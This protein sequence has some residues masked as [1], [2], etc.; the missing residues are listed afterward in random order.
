MKTSVA[1][2]AVCL[3][4]C[5]MALVTTANANPTGVGENRPLE[6]AEVAQK[7]RFLKAG[8]KKGGKKGGYGGKKGGKKGG[9]SPT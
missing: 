2:T 8:G 4:V 3:A 6:D 1:T 7:E 5:I 9:Y